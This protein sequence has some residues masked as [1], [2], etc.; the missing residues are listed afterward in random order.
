MCVPHD[1]KTVTFT[2]PTELDDHLPQQLGAVLLRQRPVP[3]LCR[4]RVL[5]A[6]DDLA[7]DRLLVGQLCAVRLIHFLVYMTVGNL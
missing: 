2:H 6:P 3:K 1:D 4:G 7:V 5:R